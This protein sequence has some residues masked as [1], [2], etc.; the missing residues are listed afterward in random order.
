MEVL[1]RFGAGAVLSLAA[2]S[3]VAAAPA[4][5]AEGYS[6]SSVEAAFL[7]RFVSY[8]GWP[9][10]GQSGEP[11]V[12]AVLDAPAVAHELQRLLPSL[13]ANRQLPEVHE[14]STVR[15]LGTPQILFIGAGHANLLR[16]DV[17]PRD[18]PMLIVTNEEGGLD[19]GSVV[20]FLTVDHRVRF[21]VSL[22]AADRSRLKISSELL[23]VAVRVLG[24]RRQSRGGCLPGDCTIRE[25]RT[26]SGAAVP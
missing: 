6:E 3:M 14:I 18:H 16:T 26:G 12:I 23:A 7:Y 19:D 9:E 24:G 2:L 10:Q 4:R 17:L 15:G 22:T 21:E 5:S 1:S 8:V 25:A 11:F 13:A 20:N